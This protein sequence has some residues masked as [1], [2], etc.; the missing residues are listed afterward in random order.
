M[1]SLNLG[2]CGVLAVYVKLISLY[3]SDIFE[4]DLLCLRVLFQRQDKKKY[5]PTM[6]AGRIFLLIVS[7]VLGNLFPVRVI[8]FSNYKHVF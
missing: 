2:D 4:F 7:Q 1:E 3:I 6:K 8:N 5:Y